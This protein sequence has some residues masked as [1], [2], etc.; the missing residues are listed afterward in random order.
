MGIYHSSKDARAYALSAADRSAWQTFMDV[1][2]YLLTAAGQGMAWYEILRR[3]FSA[4]QRQSEHDDVRLLVRCSPLAKYGF[5]LVAGIW[6]Y[7]FGKMGEITEACVQAVVQGFGVSLSTGAW[8]VVKATWALFG[9]GFILWNSGR[10]CFW[11]AESAF[12]LERREDG[13]G[14]D[15]SQ[16]ATR[17]VEMA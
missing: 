8:E 14:G 12:P 2:W 6:M 7:G 13:S 1:F 15:K 11:V 3:L 10:F 5:I 17:D 4:P 16:T 9:E